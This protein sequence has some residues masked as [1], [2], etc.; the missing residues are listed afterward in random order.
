MMITIGLVNATFLVQEIVKY[1]IAE[2]VNIIIALVAIVLGIDKFVSWM[3]KKRQDC[4]EE[5]S[6]KD[7]LES[8]VE[9]DH[10]KLAA[11]EAQI[12]ALTDCVKEILGND[13][14]E[15]RDKFMSRQPK[16]YITKYERMMQINMYNA[17]SAISP[18]DKIV[19]GFHNE[20]LNL[21]IKDVKDFQTTT[22]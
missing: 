22:S 9:T 1:P 4:Y 19:K 11:M 13:L 2:V 5:I 18:N 10:D 12:N 7:S 17:Y 16:P 14:M 21:P 8:M 3:K 20:V 6:N 15:S